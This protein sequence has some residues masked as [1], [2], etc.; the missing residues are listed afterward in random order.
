M[1]NA[2]AARAL[3]ATALAF[4]WA[5][6]GAP[7]DDVNGADLVQQ[8]GDFVF[9]ITGLA[10]PE[11]VK[12]DPDQDVYFVSNF[13]EGEDDRANDGFLARV[14]AVDGAVE[15]LRWATGPDATPL[16]EP[17]GMALAGDT[18]WV[19]DADGVHAF[20][21]V[22]GEHLAFV[23][24]TALEPGFLNDLAMGPDGALY[25]TDTGTSSVY[26]VTAGEATVA[27]SGRRLGSPNGITWNDEARHFVLVPWREGEPIRGWDPSSDDLSVVGRS[28]GGRFDGIEP[29]PG[30][31]VVASQQ[32]SALHMLVAGE[33]R[34]I[35]RVAGRPADI[36]V[37]SRR[38]R[39]A[40]PYIDL[41]R[42]DVFQL[43]ADAPP[44]SGP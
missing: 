42:V 36:A 40:V 12:Y 31:F 37:D 2:P 39:V 44:V 1:R 25:V 24:M 38:G 29:I 14:A 30:G 4:A 18:L 3:L 32:D 15:T 27:I 41:N 19:A 6:Q 11:A 33:G 28:P 26:R 9:Q 22:S 13:G 5:C 16:R 10:G 34:V 20:H 8:P 7:D 21:R 23:D 35:V 17:R 43:P